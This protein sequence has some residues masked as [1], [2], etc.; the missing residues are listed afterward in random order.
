[1]KTLRVGATDF[2]QA[3]QHGLA[4]ML[5]MLALATP[6]QAEFVTSPRLAGWLEEAAKPGG[7]FEKRTMALGFVAGIHDV[8]LDSWV[9]TPDHVR[10]RKLL[11]A[12][13]SWM[14]RNP[15]KWD[16]MAAVTVRRALI[17]TYPCPAEPK[18]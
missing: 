6:A 14:I 16:E 15:D 4:A 2:R 8:L 7:D 5:L 11:L 18:P 10:G 17:E 9:C 13:R 12:V 1:M 3:L